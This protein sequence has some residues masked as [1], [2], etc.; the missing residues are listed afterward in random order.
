M[1]LTDFLQLDAPI[2]HS[3]LPSTKDLESACNRV[4][5]RWPDIEPAPQHGREAMALAMLRRVRDDAWQGARLAEVIR[6]GRV[7]FDSEYLERK[8]FDTVRDFYSREAQA[9]TNKAFLSAVMSIYI[10]SFEPNGRHTAALAF[11]L[12]EAHDR[13]GE[14]W[15]RLLDRVPSLFDA[16][17]VASRLGN[18]MSSMAS[19]W[20]ELQSMGFR[21]PHA[22]GLLYHV[23][24]EYVIQMGPRMTRRLYIERMLG[25]LSPADGDS[26]L[27]G[28]AQAVD[29]LL[30]PW[31]KRQ[32]SDD[33]RDLLVD[34]L[35]SAYGDPRVK[36]GGMWS[37]IREDCR[38]GLVRWLTRANI[39]FFLDVVSESEASHMWRPRR[40]FWSGLY[41]DGLI[42]DAWVAFCPRAEHEAERLIEQSNDAPNLAYA[43]QTHGGRSSTSLLVLKI[44]RCVVIEG[45]HSYKVQIFRDDDPQ[46]PE[47][48]KASYDCERIRR[49]KKYGEVIHL[50]AW[51]ERVLDLIERARF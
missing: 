47:L 3:A 32:P 36:K 26:L 33:I 28:A 42:E 1:K 21:N 25:W 45:S 51:G 20:V 37:E 24:L 17:Y 23:H 19:P 13:I 12:R 7:V 15:V 10:A 6:A 34:R 38:N 46:A 9:S 4:L 5:T 22:Q 14:R 8:E 31:T 27:S 41:E 30:A 43:R 39:H 11:V 29:A 49:T 44:G 35:I 48:F 40:E 2:Q 50:G 16:R 18:T